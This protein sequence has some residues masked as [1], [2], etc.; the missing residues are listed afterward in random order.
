MISVR[1]LLVGGVSPL[2]MKSP[3]LLRVNVNLIL[4]YWNAER[5]KVRMQKEIKMEF[6]KR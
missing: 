3:Y 2:R 4:L 1:P 6:R 5:D